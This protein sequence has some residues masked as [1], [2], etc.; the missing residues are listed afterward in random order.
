MAISHFDHSTT[1]LLSAHFKHDPPEINGQSAA[2][3][4][5][6]SSHCFDCD[7]VL[8]SFFLQLHNLDIRLENSNFHP[9]AFHQR[10]LHLLSLFARLSFSS[11]ISWQSYHIPLYSH[12]TWPPFFFD[13]VSDVLYHILNHIHITFF[14]IFTW[15]FPS[16]SILLKI[17]SPVY[18]YQ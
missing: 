3:K 5:I 1:L 8:I 2:A 11:G 9:E 18:L 17:F 14:T 16:F 7:F 6:L 12:P 4:M 15:F 10:A 13:E